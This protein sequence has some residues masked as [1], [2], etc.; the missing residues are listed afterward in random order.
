M[1]DFLKTE[2]SSVES[3]ESNSLNSI[4]ISPSIS[5][6]NFFDYKN[7]SIINELDFIIL[8]RNES[9]IGNPSESFKLQFNNLDFF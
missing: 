9:S 7:Y 3:F 2:L 8:K 1:N 4:P 5:Y 6:I